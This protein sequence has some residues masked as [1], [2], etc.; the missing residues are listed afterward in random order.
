MVLLG[1]CSVFGARWKSR[2]RT[3]VRPFGYLL[4]A[5][6][7]I[8]DKVKAISESNF[9]PRILRK[10]IYDA[11]SKLKVDNEAENSDDEN[12][13]FKNLSDLR[14]PGAL[15]EL[16]CYIDFIEEHLIPAS[17]QFHFDRNLKPE[18]VR[19][20][21]LDYL[22]DTGQ[23][24]YIKPAN[25]RGKPEPTQQRIKR[26]YCIT[27]TFRNC[28]CVTYQCSHR[29]PPSLWSGTTYF[30]DHNEESY[31]MRMAS[32]VILPWEGEKKIDTLS[33]FPLDYL[34]ESDSKSF[35]QN[36]FREPHL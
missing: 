33:M 34:P 6:D 11:T 17:C 5:H 14:E 2:P 23:Y 35:R 12:N 1:T 31:G 18:T 16:R 27:N 4:Q 22:F 13:A 20:E 36:K 25:R 24:V 28:I 7:L 3:F 26:I 15:E 8:K 29:Y 30:L 9:D 19:F 10:T 21:D 32:T